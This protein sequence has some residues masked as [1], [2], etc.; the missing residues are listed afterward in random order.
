MF[1]RIE[2][3]AVHRI[4]CSSLDFLH[5]STWYQRSSVEIKLTRVLT[6]LDMTSKWYYVQ[7]TATPG[8]SPENGSILSTV[9]DKMG[10]VL[11][12]EQWMQQFCELRLQSFF[13]Q[14]FQDG[15]KLCIDIG[16]TSPV[17]QYYDVLPFCCPISNC[18][19]QSFCTLM[20]EQCEMQDAR[21]SFH[22]VQTIQRG[23]Q[24]S[25]FE[26]FFQV[27]GLV[28]SFRIAVDCH[29]P[30]AISSSPKLRC[31]TPEELWE[32]KAGENMR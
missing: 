7:P 20:S 27:C 10:P 25:M 3:S 14:C 21:A 12:S 2:S 31:D 24:F 13:L 18:V 30:V 6:C 28:W 11:P 15:A 4:K 23:Q 8:F 17:L 32:V 22:Q 5:L 19:P 1:Q 9:G 16:L 29:F 26:S